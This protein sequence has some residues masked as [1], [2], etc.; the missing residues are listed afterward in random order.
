M[1]L[2]EQVARLTAQITQ[3]ERSLKGKQVY[4]EGVVRENERLQANLEAV[5]SDRVTQLASLR[6]MA[7]DNPA[8]KE[9]I[10]LAWTGE[11]NVDNGPNKEIEVRTMLNQVQPFKKKSELS[12]LIYGL[13][14]WIWNSYCILMI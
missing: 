4:C 2:Q 13:Y 6:K 11:D 7:G 5:K 8:V 1:T 12:N 9:V 3:L 14:Q 10:E